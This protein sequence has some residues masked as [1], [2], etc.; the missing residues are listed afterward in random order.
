M[1]NMKLALL[2]LC[3]LCSPS[4]LF[5]QE[6]SAPPIPP[7]PVCLGLGPHTGWDDAAQFV[8]GSSEKRYARELTPEQHTSWS[9]YQRAAGADWSRL[10]A[11]HLKPIAAW[12]GKALAQRGSG[13]VAFYPFSGPDAANVLVFYPDAKE[14]VLIGLE[15]VGCLP[16]DAA[17]YTPEYFA[18]LQH[19]LQSA[20]G[21][22][23]FK[24][25]DMRRDFRESRVSGVL[26]V[27]LMELVRSGLIITSVSESSITAD[28]TLAS[29]ST[30]AQKETSGVSIEVK[31]DRHGTRTL[32]YFSVNLQN[33]PLRKRP[34][35]LKY[36]RGLPL[37]GTIVKSAS[38]LMHKRVFS[39]IRGVILAQ[40]R[41]LV[42]DD[43]G[44]PFQFFAGEAWNVRLYGTYDKPINLFK[45]S[46][47][48]DLKTAYET[49]T[50]VEPLG[51]GMGYKWRAK[52]SN[53]L[54]AERRAK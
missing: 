45:N 41:V 30:P 16:A 37:N 7:K 43:S 32:R 36:L 4:A 54:V 18:D 23:F 3:G 47:Q 17:G 52:E 22:G 48:E 46:L 51:F 38:Y 1:S 26:P 25:N 10:Q 29:G 2:L 13:G 20:V 24:T 14:Y 12:R 28:G 40:T 49:R 6:G 15:P 50:D 44:V 8:A 53:L 39:V 42:Q 11:R 21:L 31:D 5:S 35:T 34:G 19:S 27:L 33:D 9:A